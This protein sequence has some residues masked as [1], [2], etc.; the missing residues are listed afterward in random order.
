MLPI[1]SICM[2]AHNKPVLLGKTLESIYRQSV[3]FEFETIVV[4]DGSKDGAIRAVCGKYPV[5]YH[6]IDR[7]PIFKNP[8]VARNVAYKMAKGPIIIAQSDEVLHVT[9]N[10][11]EALVRD[12]RPGTFLLANVFCL[13][14]QGQACGCYTGPGRFAP[15]F[16]LGAIFAEDVYAIGGN[17]EDFDICPAYEDDWFASCLIYGRRL[18]PIYSTSI[19]GH[20][21]WHTYSTRY[22]TEGP[23]RELFARKHL[24]ATHGQSPWAAQAG[25]WPYSGRKAVDVEE[26]FTDKWK[27]GSFCDPKSGQPPESASGAGSSHSATA[28]IRAALPGLIKELD[29]KTFFDLCC[30][31]CNWITHV[32]LGVD[33][34]I[35]GDIVAELVE[36]NEL[37]FGRKGRQ[38]IHLDLVTSD[39]PKADLVLCRDCLVHL[40]HLDVGRAIENLKRSNSTYL[41]TTTFSKR[42]NNPQ[43]AT[44]DWAPYNMKKPPFSFPPPLWLI[45][46]DCREHYPNFQDKSLGLWKLEDL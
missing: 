44:G 7:E 29:I 18:K 45:N 30:G 23:S 43:I 27:Q 24:A 10:T 37:L 17:D 33:L 32:N 13:N 9:P 40:S 6:R 22:E 39:L 2:S 26:L 38:F 25:P 19:I 34:Y 20:H 28:A 21:Q 12:L 16:F 11:V 42:E 3:P 41:L 14:Q 36:Q 5:R 4:D 1:A 31:D 35:G 8:A 15:L 46:E